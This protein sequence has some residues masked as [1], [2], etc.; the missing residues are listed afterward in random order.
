MADKRYSTSAWQRLRKAVLQRDGHSCRIQGPRC[1]GY[2]TT[3][4]HLVAS[5]ERPDL[6]WASDNLVSACTRCNY[7]DGRRVAAANGRRRLEQLEAIIIQQEERIHEQR[8]QHEADRPNPP[9]RR[10]PPK[11]AIY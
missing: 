1:T 5:S 10:H 8:A 11:P 7:G 3:V 6:F 9:L 2:A 4:H